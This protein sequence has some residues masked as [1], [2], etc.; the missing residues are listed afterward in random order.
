V[1][2]GALWA[3]LLTVTTMMAAPPPYLLPPARKDSPAMVISKETRLTPS[4]DRL[5]NHRSP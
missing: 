1:H 4:D 5:S 2:P 3:L